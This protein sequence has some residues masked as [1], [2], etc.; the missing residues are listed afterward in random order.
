MELKQ[1]TDETYNE[2]AD[3]DKKLDKVTD[4]IKPAEVVAQLLYKW[5][6]TM[7]IDKTL[8]LRY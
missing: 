5:A 2:D 3:S 1:N 8:V 6:I 4:T 7:R